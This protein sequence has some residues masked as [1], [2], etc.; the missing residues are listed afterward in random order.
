[1]SDLVKTEPLPN[2]PFDTPLGLISEQMLVSQSR[3]LLY[4]CKC[5]TKTTHNVRLG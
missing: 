5:G 4:K 3:R 1:M 2:E